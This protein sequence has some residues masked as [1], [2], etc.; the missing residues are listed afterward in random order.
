LIFALYMLASSGYLLGYKAYLQS[1]IDQQTQG[2]DTALDASANMEAQLARYQH[3]QGFMA[4]Q[5]DIGPVWWVMAEVFP[6][7]KLSR[8]DLSQGRFV[9]AGQTDRAT[10]LLEKLNNHPLVAEARFDNPTRNSRGN[11]HFV[12]SFTVK[13]MVSEPTDTPSNAVEVTANDA[14]N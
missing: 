10:S 4:Q 9:L 7:A 8:F 12:V 6:Q 13:P 3:I 2:I 11:E 14:G 1:Q 5:I